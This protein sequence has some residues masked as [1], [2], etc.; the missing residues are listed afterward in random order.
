MIQAMFFIKNKL[1]STI[2]KFYLFKFF[3]SLHFFSAVLVPFFTDWGGISLFQVQILQS[4]FAFWLFV[5]EVPTGSVADYIGRKHS[6]IIG[7]LI[8]ALAMIVY[9]T[10]PHFGLFL[11]GEFFFALGVAL[12][13]GADDALLYDS[14]KKE[15]KEEMSTA[16]FGR[17][18]S[19]NLS[20]MLTA[21]LMGGFIAAQFGLN[22]PM[23]F[24]AISVL[25]A[26][27]VILFI[28]EPK[29]KHSVSE[30]KRYLDIIKKGWQYFSTH[31]TLRS[32]TVDMVGVSLASYFI[33]WLYQPLLSSFSFPIAYFGL[34]HGG[35]IVSQI[36]VSHNFERLEKW[37]GSA[38]NYTRFTALIVALMFFIT[39][40]LPNVY[41]VLLFAF[42]AGGF[43][44][45]R[46]QF[47]TAK[48]NSF[49]E[50]EQRATVLSFLNMMRRL[51]YAIMNPIVG[52]LATQSLRAALLF[53]GIF[54]LMVFLWR[55]K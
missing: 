37:F 34:V 52:L 42:I 36:I 21:T 13:S 33:L 30:Q 7:A 38:K 6:V 45:T 10:V 25:L 48:V 8:T 54:P 19:I 26:G 29:G 40:I 24:S 49:I 2:T 3:V 46:Q 31:R 17:S 18:H 53:I 20:G 15:G 51:S 22:A 44:M 12:I 35:M 16:I 47:I 27:F 41:T 14:L 23:L 4:W 9:G 32:I 28:D 11:L 55:R 5:L 50:S 39:A 43:G 1:H